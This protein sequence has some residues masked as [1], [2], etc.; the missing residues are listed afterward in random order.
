MV[1]AVVCSMNPNIYIYIYI[2]MCVCVCRRF[3]DSASFPLWVTEVRED[4][5]S[6]ELRTKNESKIREETIPKKE[7]ASPHVVSIIHFFKLP[8]PQ[9][10]NEENKSD[11]FLMLWRIVFLHFLP[12]PFRWLVIINI[13]VT[14]DYTIEIKASVDFS[15]FFR[16]RVLETRLIKIIYIY[17]Y[18]WTTKLGLL[19]TWQGQQGG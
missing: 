18:I 3:R 16:S 4:K 12:P 1:V 15:L 9:R 14:G 17:I 13:P 6:R 10:L 19:S 7:D 5:R 2:Y 8:R 11:E